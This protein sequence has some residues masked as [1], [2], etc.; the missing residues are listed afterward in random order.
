MNS[1]NTEF[2]HSH[3]PCQIEWWAVEG[4]LNTTTNNNKFLFIAY[5]IHDSIGNTSSFIGITIFDMNSNFIYTYSDKKVPSRLIYK[6]DNCDVKYKNSFIKGKYPKYKIYLFDEL[7]NILI[8]MN[9]QSVSSLHFVGE[10]KAKGYIPFGLGYL[11]Y[12]FIPKNNIIGTITIKNKSF[13]ITGIGN[14]E[15]VWGTYRPYHI[16]DFK[17]SFSSFF[18]LLIWKM[19][20]TEVHLPKSI[21]LSLENGP[22]SNDWSWI[23]FNN[24]WT[25]FYANLLLW[26]MS[27]PGASVL[28][29]TKNGK[30]YEEFG[31]VNFEYKKL[32]YEN[33]YNFY[34]PI[35]F[36]IT[37]KKQD[38]L[39]TL[40]FKNQSKCSFMPLHLNQ[41]PPMSKFYSVF[42]VSDSHSI[43]EGF[44]F[45]GGKNIKL[46][47]E[48]IL[49]FERLVPKI[50]HNLIKFNFLY[51]P[52]GLGFKIYINSHFL[53]KRIIAEIN[54]AKQ[55]F[56][57]IKFKRISLKDFLNQITL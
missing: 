57:K 13:K 56:I 47:G 48:A 17:K 33:N 45:E 2:D 35:E 50:G 37:A 11:K 41:E 5:F 4:I 40:N 46:N 26:T 23:V 34:Y 32:N 6:K 12:G 21:S 36:N 3:F 18:K 53:K 14:F 29:L 16:S 1:I 39:I 42:A 22:F 8:D 49:E 38:K 9:F 51:P 30:I 44:Y 54:I 15:H 31:N 20:E 7:N 43:V 27:G 55:P 28:I 24:G 25:I 10:E 19:K 52:K